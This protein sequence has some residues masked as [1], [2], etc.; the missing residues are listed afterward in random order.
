MIWKQKLKEE[1]ED[2]FGGII[3]LKGRILTSDERLPLYEKTEKLK[4]NY[5]MKNFKAIPYFLWANR[6]KSKM[7]VWIGKK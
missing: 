2:I 5:K 3:T 7:A 1:F 6:G 4:I